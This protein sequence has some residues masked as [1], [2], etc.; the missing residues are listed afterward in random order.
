MAVHHLC[1]ANLQ[2]RCIKRC[3]MDVS[4]LLSSLTLS[5]WDNLSIGLRKAKINFLVA[6]Y[7]YRLV[8]LFSVT[9]CSPCFQR[10]PPWP[11]TQEVKHC[12]NYN[13]A[14]VIITQNLVNHFLS[15]SSFMSFMRSTR[16]YLHFKS[17]CSD[18]RISLPP[19]LFCTPSSCPICLHAKCYW[20]PSLE[21]Q[22]NRK[23]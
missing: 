22:Q 17:R 21:L 23:P 1:R 16:S 14:E 8:A 11:I 6:F 7:S 4:W 10:K 5:T 12:S 9:Y 20:P 18:R 2:Y 15:F 3:T 19:T 13:N